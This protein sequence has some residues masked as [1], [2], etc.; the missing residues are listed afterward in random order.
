LDPATNANATLALLIYSASVSAVLEDA[1][2]ETHYAPLV[3]T[4]RQAA[5]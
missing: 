4:L 1:G 5:P 2:G 3:L